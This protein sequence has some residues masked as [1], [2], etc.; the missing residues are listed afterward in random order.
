MS[1]EGLRVKGEG[2]RV[3]GEGLCLVKGEGNHWLR[4]KGTIG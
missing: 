4:V 2:L 1:G 3:K